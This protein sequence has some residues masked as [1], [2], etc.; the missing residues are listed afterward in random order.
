MKVRAEDLGYHRTWQDFKVED[1]EGYTPNMNHLHSHSYYEISM[2]LRGNVTV[3]M[4][5]STESISSEGRDC[6]ILLLRPHTPHLIVPHP[7]TLYKR[8]NILFRA[9]FLS[10]VG[11]EWRELCQLLE[12]N[13]LM[14]HPDSETLQKCMTLSQ[15]MREETD[16]SRVRLLLLYFLSLLSDLRSTEVKGAEIPAFIRLSLGYIAEH[17]AERITAE[18][19]ADRV[20]VGRTTLMTGFRRYTGSS[21]CEYI[22]RYRL[23][24]A[25]ACLE[26]GMTEQ[27]T[28]EVCG[29][30]TACY[31][32]RV[33][34]KHLGASPMAYLKQSKRG[35]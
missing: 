19:L 6:R 28:A 9:D 20:G 7:D 12:R 1:Y 8:R 2:I 29:F 4:G 22:T 24:R 32:I 30:G 15:T 35:G 14:L 18:E 21:L 11:E 5:D 25:I 26:S 10:A 33:F 31:L 3:L 17:Y 27:E 34:K 16:L 13:S 23:R